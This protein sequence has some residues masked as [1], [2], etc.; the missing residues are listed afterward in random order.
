MKRVVTVDLNGMSFNFDE[1]AYDALRSYMR[2]AEAQLASDPGRTEVLA[3]L[4]RSIADKCQGVLNAQK[5][6]V[7]H[8]EMRAVLATI[9]VVNG[10]AEDLN[11]HGA[12]TSYERA[13]TRRQLTQVREGAMISGVCNGLAT[14]FGFDV[15][16]L[17][18]IF[19][20]LAIVTS[21][22]FVLAYGAMMFLLPYDT[23]VEKINDQSIPGF[24]FKL[25]THT[26]RKL[27]GTS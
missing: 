9:G 1:D 15:T 6:V 18:V 11:S 20:I 21:G 12:G 24:M 22:A 17:R 19:V 23:D 13:T 27:A 2:R 10:T 26:K 4:E 25:V 7:T 8:E 16:L 5:N 3:D 14:H